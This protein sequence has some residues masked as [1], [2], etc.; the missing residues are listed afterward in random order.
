MNPHRCDHTVMQVQFGHMQC[1]LYRG[2]GTT[3]HVNIGFGADHGEYAWEAED[4]PHKK[5]DGVVTEYL[6]ADELDAM[7]H[8]SAFVRAIRSTVGDGHDGHELVDKVHQLQAMVMS[9]AAGRAYPERFRL[10]G[11]IK[12]ANNG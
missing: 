6:T 7:D 10:L 8:L 2:H 5:D 12:R 9:Q 1:E 4:A 11:E 3:H